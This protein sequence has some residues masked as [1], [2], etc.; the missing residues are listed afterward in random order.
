MRFV[1]GSSRPDPGKVGP[2]TLG[3][4]G[5]RFRRCRRTFVDSAAPTAS[6]PHQ[7]DVAVNE[8]LM[9][10]RILLAD[11]C[12]AIHRGITLLLDS[13]D[14]E[15]VAAAHDGNEAVRLALACRPD[16]AILDQSMPGLTGISA[17][18]AIR[19]QLPEVHLILLTA[20][21]TEHEV[22]LALAAGIRACVLKNDA[23]D[24]L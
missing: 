1:R 15:V 21:V 16:V 19:A 22:A 11:D 24:D 17:A 5:L 13:A 18:R 3:L 14:F 7:R 8:V 12:P 2:R 20:S 6:D 23:T 10:I 9:P 4:P